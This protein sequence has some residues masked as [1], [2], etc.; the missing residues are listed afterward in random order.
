MKITR[1]EVCVIEIPLRMTVQHALAER[2]SAR[3]V[4]VA[5][6]SDTGLVGWGESCPRSYVTGESVESVIT[7]LR[8][9]VLPG[10]LGREYASM[11]ALEDELTEVLDALSRSQQAAFCPAELALLDLVGRELGTSAGGVL[12]PLCAEKVHYS[13]VIAVGD[14]S[15]VTASAAFLRDF[16]V[17]E[18]KVKVGASLE[19]NLAVLRTAREVLGEAVS[20][21]VD[22]NGAWSGEE[23]LRQLQ[24]MV[25]FSLVGV[26]QPCAG[27]DIDGMKMVTAAGLVPVVADE[28]VASVGDA[29]RL[30]DELA[31]N[32]F[33]I[34]ISKCGGLINAG[35][36]YRM[37]ME[38]GLS[39]QLGA[40]V[41]ETGILSAA[42]RQFATRCSDLLWL[43]GSYGSLLLEQDI[44][45][46]DTTVGP[47]GVAPALD[48]PGLG[49]EPQ[50]QRL[51]RY[52][53]D[54]SVVG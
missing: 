29:A 51:E 46:P 26:E 33:N 47:G 34:R 36:L 25:E 7:E 52:V 2:K 42:G 48:T 41:G 40:Q 53:R 50:M 44:T 20:L 8:G 3:N 28:S 13:G 45:R 10:F 35:R 37:A 32:V 16:G 27:D 19:N 38:A 9:N 15:A 54:I 24:A 1:F 14:S 6:H 5:A 31:C 39:C 49:V 23:A 4:L 12:G 22:A 18:V 30:I 43:E 17:Q 21:R 11:E